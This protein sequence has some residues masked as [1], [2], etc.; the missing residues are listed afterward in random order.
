M[1]RTISA[2]K[3]IEITSLSR[4]MLWRLE[5]AGSFPA[6]LRMSAGRKA[7]VAAEVHAWLA[8]RA[9]ARRPT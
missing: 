3:V 5:R 1:M 6:A 9:N 8:A 2:Q 7:Y 4:S